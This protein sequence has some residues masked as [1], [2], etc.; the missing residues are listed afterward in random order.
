MYADFVAYN[1]RKAVVWGGHSGNLSRFAEFFPVL[2]RPVEYFVDRYAV[3]YL[4]LDEAYV[5]PDRLGL[6]SSL[7]A[8]DRFGPITV[9]EFV[10]RPAMLQPDLAAH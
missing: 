8:L 9:Y 1:G 2:R 6:E 7:A 10:R 3:D 4:V 5:R